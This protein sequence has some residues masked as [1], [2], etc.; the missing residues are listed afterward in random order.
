MW[1]CGLC[2]RLLQTLK[3]WG[4]IAA[5]GTPKGVQ[6]WVDAV[7]REA[8]A[9]SFFSSWM[10]R[11]GLR[12]FSTVEK[13]EL[14]GREEGV[15]AE[16]QNLQEADRDEQESSISSGIDRAGSPCEEM[17]Q[18]S[19]PCVPFSRKVLV[20][21]GRCSWLT[22]W[23]AMYLLSPDGSGECKSVEILRFCTMVMVVLQTKFLTS[24]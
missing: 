10:S 22:I 18:P 5:T 24:S 8:L 13:S 1:R 6:G 9:A 17:S 3:P 23:Q 12:T 16:L 7:T 4:S 15:G 21:S 11:V 19:R 2:L 14:W 20:A